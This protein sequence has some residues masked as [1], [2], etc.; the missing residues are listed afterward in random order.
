MRSTVSDIVK[1]IADKMSAEGGEFQLV[2]SL[3]VPHHWI[4]NSLTPTA[5][6]E[7]DGM[8]L[9]HLSRSVDTPL[10]GQWTDIGFQIS[11]I[12]PDIAVSFTAVY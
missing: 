12:I 9:S 6:T 4:P 1:I 3:C 10:L 5:V 2:T 7:V 8:V 11:K